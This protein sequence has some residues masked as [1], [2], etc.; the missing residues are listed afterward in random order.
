MHCS[1]LRP[2]RTFAIFT[3]LALAALTSSC[4]FFG[5]ITSHRPKPVIGVILPFSSAFTAIAEE[6]QNAIQ[7]ALRDSGGDATVVFKDG[8]ADSETALHAFQDLAAMNPAPDAVITCASW[9]ATALHPVAAGRDIFHVVIG[10]AAF[11]RKVPRHTVRFTLDAKLEEHQLS[12]YLDRFQRIAVLNMDNGYGNNWAQVLRNGFGDRIVASIAYDPEAASFAKPLQKIKQARPDALVLLSAGNAARIARKAREIGIDA[13]FVGTRPI[14][15]PEL[16]EA[17]KYTNGLVY[18]YPSYNTKHHLL[19]DYRA[20]YGTPPTIFA[21]ETY[22]AMTTLLEALAET[23]RSTDALFDW[24]AGRT[25]TGALGEVRFN[26]IGDAIYPY[27]MKEIAD[28]RFRVAPFQFPLLLEATRADIAKAFGEM[29]ANLAKAATVLGKIGTKGDAARAVLQ[30][31]CDT[32]PHIYDCVTVNPKGIIVNVAPAEFQKVVGADI[33]DQEQIKRL[34]A[35]K[36]PVVSHAIDTVEGFVGFDLERPLFTPEGWFIGS[37]SI[38]T[39]PDFFGHVITPRIANF[40]VEIWVMQPDG[41]IV[42]DAN[43]EEIGENL[44]TSAIYAD[45]P[46]LVAAGRRMAAGAEGSGAYEFLD[47]KMDRKVRKRLLW[48]TVELHGTEFRLALAHVDNALE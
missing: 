40:P 5:N 29:D 9:V 26:E 30:D 8:G 35:T 3:I 41:R 48:T 38:L 36:K 19:A 23:D 33:S 17:A 43:E 21:C 34:Q 20:A 2:Q 14:E 12:A 44:F 1:I 47:K 27:M 37:V 24:Y 6:Q 18:T 42:Y 31:L 25:Y 39:E 10:S 46:S 22:D 7:M 28:G 11:D 15:R 16:L 13:Q 32:T 4:A 45:Y